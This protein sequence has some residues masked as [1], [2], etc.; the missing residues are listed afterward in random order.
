[1]PILRADLPAVRKA[2]LDLDCVVA[3]PTRSNP[4]AR[5]LADDWFADTAPPDEGFPIQLTAETAVGPAQLWI[6]A[7]E[8]FLPC[9]QPTNGPDR[10]NHDHFRNRDIANSSELNSRLRASL[11]KFHQN[12]L[13]G[14]FRACL[15]DQIAKDEMQ[16]AIVDLIEQ[17]DTFLGD[18]R[19]VASDRTD[20]PFE[21]F[22][23]RIGGKPLDLSHAPLRRDLLIALWDSKK[24]QPCPS[25]EV[26]DVIDAIYPD[27]DES[28]DKLKNLYKKVNTKEFRPNA[29][30]AKISTRRG[31]IWLKHLST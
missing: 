16:V 23:F 1:M 8:V 24:Y 9:L 30:A 31:K 3:N 29:V 6:A 26:G 22:G 20:G 13:R 14:P 7:V 5:K 18:E 11:S 28:E 4:L 15:M 27:D 10:V 2:L 25:R 12:I 21:P 19:Q 17:I